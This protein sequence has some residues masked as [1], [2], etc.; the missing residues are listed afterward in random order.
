MPTFTVL[1]RLENTDGT[2]M[3]GLHVDRDGTVSMYDYGEQFVNQ[4]IPDFVNAASVGGPGGFGA[5]FVHLGDC[6]NAG[7][8]PSDARYD[9]DGDIRPEV[10]ACFYGSPLHKD[11]VEWAIQQTIIRRRAVARA[12]LRTS[13]KQRMRPIADW[14][15]RVPHRPEFD[16]AVEAQR[17]AF[18]AK[19]F[20]D[21]EKQL[22]AVGNCMV[23]SAILAFGFDH[24][25][26]CMY[27]F[28]RSLEQ[29]SF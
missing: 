2:L 15:A 19:G 23:R 16:E 22:V 8:N 27:T 5:L 20:E 7:T 4:V 26:M 24:S 29:E 9:P 1:E 28:I 11:A 21:I 10:V 13:V 25:S 6:W 14:C 3:E 12:Q 17:V 18:L